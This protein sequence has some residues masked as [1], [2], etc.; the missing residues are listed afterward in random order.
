MAAVV[1]RAGG[2]LGTTGGATDF[3]VSDPTGGV[4]PRLVSHQPRASAS[5]KAAE[6]AA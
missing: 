1:G 4:S 2:S 5:S 3:A 6:K